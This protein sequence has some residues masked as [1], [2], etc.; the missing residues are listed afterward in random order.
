MVVNREIVG[1]ELFDGYSDLED[2]LDIIDMNPLE[3]ECLRNK[4]ELDNDSYD[5]YAGDSFKEILKYIE[6][7][8]LIFSTC[9]FGMNPEQV[10]AVV[11]FVKDVICGDVILN[12]NTVRV[13]SGPMHLYN[14]K[15][16]ILAKNTL[17][18]DATTVIQR[19]EELLENTLS[20]NLYIECIGSLLDNEDSEDLGEIVKSDNIVL[21]Y[22]DKMQSMQGFAIIKFN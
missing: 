13:Y 6:E 2:L 12:K 11:S 9:V 21:V 20:A 8:D 3:R 15:F 18:P 22:Y 7:K 17:R 10:N 19:Q 14:S 4:L 1:N 16:I 5:Y